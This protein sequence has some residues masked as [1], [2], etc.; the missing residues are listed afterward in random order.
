[1][2]LLCQTKSKSEKVKALVI[3]KHLMRQAFF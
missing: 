2:I 3:P 1:M